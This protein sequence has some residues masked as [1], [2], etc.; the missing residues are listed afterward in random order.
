MTALPRRRRSM[1]AAALVALA[2]L[3]G[4]SPTETIAGLHAAPAEKAAV[5][6]L[7]V[8]AAQRITARVLQAADAAE[9]QPA[10]EAGK[11]ARA[12]VLSGNAADLAAA[13]IAVN[14]VVP[15]TPE[16]SLLRP[17]V[18]K[19]LGVSRGMGFPRVI[20]ATT[21][22]ETTNR[23]YLETLVS[24]EV[25]APFTLENRIAM[26]PGATLPGLGDVV[27]GMPLAGLDDAQ[28]LALSPKAALEAYAAALTYPSPVANDAVDTTDTFAANL[29][30]NQK[31][32]A[33]ALGALATY[34]VSQTPVPEAIRA[35][36]LADGSVVVFG[37]INRS[38]E[39]R[40]TESAKEIKVPEAYQKLTG[41]ATA[42]S[43][44]T[45]STMQPVVLHIPARGKG[46]VALIGVLEQ[47]T[48]GSAS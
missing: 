17:A 42:T 21:L 4:C 20:L 43:T 34:T 10:D 2:L 46:K 38:D 8:A 26:L 24:P 41:T 31:K 11:A 7:P 44:I 5:A 33:E 28:G 27:A 45:I 16:A 1:L 29:V 18:P 14:G 23:Q 35:I 48:G 9:T 15:Q 39:L 25:T 3:T 40:A 22:D 13:R 19:V 30:A 32:Q 6:P 47:I 36:R 37:R 12:A